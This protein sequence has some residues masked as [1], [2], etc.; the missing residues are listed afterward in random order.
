M[1]GTIIVHRYQEKSLSRLTTKR[2]GRGGG[3][4]GIP[5]SQGHP[6]H[7]C[8]GCTGGDRPQGRA[9]AGKEVSQGRSPRKVPW[10]GPCQV[11]VVGMMV[12]LF[13]YITSQQPYKIR[14]AFPHYR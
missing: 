10:P 5:A 7:W 4:Q 9:P 6:G 2:F 12:A 3:G 8:L 1:E 14:V 13:S 11:V